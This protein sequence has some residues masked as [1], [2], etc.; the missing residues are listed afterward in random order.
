MPKVALAARATGR[1]E[2]K[3]GREE[4]KKKKKNY[5]TQKHNSHGNS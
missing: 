3:R 5:L 1:E 4:K 2:T